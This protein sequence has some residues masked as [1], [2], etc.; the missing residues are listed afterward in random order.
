MNYERKSK[1]QRANDWLTWKKV[2][3]IALMIALIGL[4]AILP[5]CYI[6]NRQIDADLRANEIDYQYKIRSLSDPLPEGVMND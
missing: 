6:L 1:L 2:P 4:M 3:A 5:I